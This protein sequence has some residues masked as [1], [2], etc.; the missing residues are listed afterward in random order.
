MKILI[1]D[2]DTDNLM[3]VKEF[4]QDDY[5]VVLESNS[6]VVLNLIYESDP[7]FDIILLDWNMPAPDGMEIL[8]ELKQNPKFEQYSNIP[9]ILQTA[10]SL[11]RD[12]IKGIQK[13]AV[14]YLTKPFS[15]QR[16]FTVVKSAEQYRLS[17]KEADRIE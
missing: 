16:L 14:H 2:D 1:V 17:Q 9:V 4:L 3:L 6:E 10:R 5:D 7:P 11:E 15:E 12:Y 8:E 13:G